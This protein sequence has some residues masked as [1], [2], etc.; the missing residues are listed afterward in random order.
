VP[1]LDGIPVRREPEPWRVGRRTALKALGGGLASLVGLLSCVRKPP[2]EVVSRESRA[3]YRKPGRTLHYATTWAD[4][5][6]P[7]G[8]LVATVEGRPIRVDGNPDHPV[9]RGASN[10]AMAASLFG[11][12]DP[13][14]LKRPPGSWSEVDAQI[15][16]ALASART[17]VLLTGPGLGPSER[18]VVH[19]FLT[20]FPRTTWFQYDPMADRE[21]RLAW[22]DCYGWDGEWVPRLDRARVILSVDSDFL[23]TDGAELENARLFAQTRVPPDETLSSVEVSRLYMVESGLSLTGT[24][25]D[26]RIPLRPSLARRFLATLRRALGGC[27]EVSSEGLGLDKS[28]FCGLASDLANH[29][30]E[31]VVLA[32]PHL[33][34]EAHIE[35]ALLNEALDAPGRTLEWNPVPPFAIP[36]S[37]DEIARQIPANPD[38]LIVLG[39]DPVYSWPEFREVIGR[40]RLSVVH[41]LKRNATMAAASL[42]LPSHHALESFGDFHPRPGLWSLVQPVVSPLYDTRQEAQSLLEWCAPDGA[43]APR[44]E[45]LVRERALAGP[46]AS[47]PHPERAWQEALRAGVIIAP[48]SA[49]EEGRRC[50]LTLPSDAYPVRDAAPGLE[51][52]LARHDAVWDGRFA[53]NPALLEAPDP[54]T[55]QMWGN[56]LIIGESTAREHGLASGD[57]VTLKS[58]HGSVEAAVVVL[59][60]VAAGTLTLHPGFGKPTFLDPGAP[61]G[62][63]GFGLA[64]GS[65]VVERVTPEP[66]GRRAS[67]IFS[68][69]TF[70]LHGRPLVL[71]AT[72]KDLRRDPDAIQK[73]RRLPESNALYQPPETPDG[74]RWAMVVDLT[75]CTGCR[76]CVLACQ[77]ENNIPVVGPEE[78]R[79]GREMH[80]IRIDQ[81][82]IETAGGLLVLHEPMPC[83]QCENAP[84]EN[85]CPVNATNHS[86]EGLND[87]VYNRCIG[88]RYCANNCPYKVRRFNFFNYARRSLKDPVQKLGFNPNVTVRQ[89]GVMEK[90]TFC[91]QRIQE[92]RF[93]AGLEGRAMRDQEVVPACAQACPTR[94]I[95]F[96]D[97]RHRTPDGQPGVV[98]RL[99]ASRRAFRVLEELRVEP[100]VTYLAK[101]RN[102]A[103][104][105]DRPGLGSDEG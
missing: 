32:G 21:R 36:N 69:E 37:R 100:R 94:A 18:E 29:R 97:A 14:R 60:G 55:K 31:A 34:R 2:R 17:I 71:H 92:A 102:P 15:R 40:A 93:R 85:V 27:T 56:A 50:S 61:V 83:Q 59:P 64:R 39:V 26:V 25:A 20:R 11:L 46:L 90:C 65:L 53:D 28:L 54:V 73:Q 1:S 103:F 24:N 81:Y 89:I 49:S 87:M 68:Q 80:W 10:A 82:R 33:P 9:N 7:Y 5:W 43:P 84:C 12:Y 105:A 78:A 48:D 38:V 74:P 47:A 72:T 91:V 70:S 58:E 51:L 67:L 30:G 6:Y 76:A 96:G 98:A 45:D 66:T 75:R 4:G 35:T 95:V 42:G 88:T 104:G 41:G 99:S 86:P 23:A 44:F 22:R 13:E 79:K 8:L 62:V 52:V 19:R 101:V 63:N 57:L 3:E 77:V 16:S